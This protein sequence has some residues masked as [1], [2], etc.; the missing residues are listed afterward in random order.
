MTS[1]SIFFSVLVC[2]TVSFPVFSQSVE[3]AAD[4]K[5]SGGL[6]FSGFSS[7]DQDTFT[8]DLPGI[9]I[10]DGKV[11]QGTMVSFVSSANNS[12]E[13][14]LKVDNGAQITSAQPIVK[15]G[16]V[17]LQ[18]NDIVVGEIVLVIFDTSTYHLLSGI[19]IPSYLTQCGNQ[20]VN[21]QSDEAHCGE[22]DNACPPGHL[23]V[24][25]DC[26]LS[27]QNGLSACNDTCRDT[28][29]DRLHCGSCGAP[30]ASGEICSNGTCV[31]SCPPGQ[32][33]CNGVCVDTENNENHCGSCNSPCGPG[34]ICSAGTCVLSC[35]PGLTQC[36]GICVDTQTDEDFCGSCAISCDPGQYC[37]NGICQD[38]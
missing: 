25:G 6:N 7:F 13:S 21:L 4:L 29:T 11:P 19:D 38:P 10:A 3:V 18:A 17:L 16:T 32:M 5:V 12:G 26:I 23:C 34:E 1:H 24:D 36:G 9:V 33:L 35:P 8:I 31:L 15:R 2:I 37:V 30:C 28:Q 22:C 20:L 14:Y 27:C